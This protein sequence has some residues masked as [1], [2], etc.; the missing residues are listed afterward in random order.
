[1]LLA[2]CLVTQIIIWGRSGW[3]KNRQKRVSS[4]EHRRC[5]MVVGTGKRYGCY[6]QR[7]WGP[8]Y[9]YYWCCRGKGPYSDHD[10]IALISSVSNPL[11]HCRWFYRDLT[12]TGI[13]ETS[14]MAHPFS[15]I[16]DVFTE[17]S[18]RHEGPYRRICNLKNTGKDDDTI[19]DF[20]MTEVEEVEEIAALSEAAAAAK[21]WCEY[22]RHGSHISEHIPYGSYPCKGQCSGGDSPG[23][24]TWLLLLWFL[25]F[26]SLRLE[27]RL[28]LLLVCCYRPPGTTINDASFFVVSC[29]L[30][31]RYHHRLPIRRIV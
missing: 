4:R 3:S 25:L 27:L 6:P 21:C 29:L 28:L 22:Y 11:L 14:M 16:D 30:R 10:A 13:T 19:I 17:N 1:M 31:H 18:S 20:I 15:V 23:E 12:E 24:S 8:Y 2:L 7:R 5:V 26:E 9:E